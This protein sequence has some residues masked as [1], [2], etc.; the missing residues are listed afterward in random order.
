MGTKFYIDRLIL[1]QD[2]NRLKYEKNINDAIQK[3]ILTGTDEDF[4]KATGLMNKTKVT[5]E[6]FKKKEEEF[7]KKK[8]Y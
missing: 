6:E 4:V 5:E 3:Y 7:K 1:N 2:N 8:H